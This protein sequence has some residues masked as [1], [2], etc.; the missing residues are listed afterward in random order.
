[1]S[2]QCKEPGHQ[3]DSFQLQ[4]SDT[5]PNLVA[6]IWPP[7]LQCSTS[8]FHDTRPNAHF[9]EIQTSNIQFLYNNRIFLPVWSMILPVWDGWLGTTLVPT[10]ICRSACQCR[11][12]HRTHSVPG[13]AS[14]W[15]HQWSSGAVGRGVTSFINP[16]IINSLAPG[17]S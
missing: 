8:T 12:S 11:P 1:M 3:L 15:Q 16:S 17:R 5:K 6:K 2:W 14:R 7:T 13:P 4:H 9:E 10:R